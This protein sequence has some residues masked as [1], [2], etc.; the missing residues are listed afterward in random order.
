[1]SQIVPCQGGVYRKNVTILVAEIQKF[2]REV[3]VV[4]LLEAETIGN[5]PTVTRY[6]DVE[7]ALREL[8][9]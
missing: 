9:S 6:T 3:A 1:V 5:D 8:K 7:E 2:R 4:A